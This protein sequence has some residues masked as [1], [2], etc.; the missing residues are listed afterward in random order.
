MTLYPF[1]YELIFKGVINNY[2]LVI[3]I[4]TLL[5]IILIQNMCT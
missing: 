1:F 3:D 2:V 4:I 5:F